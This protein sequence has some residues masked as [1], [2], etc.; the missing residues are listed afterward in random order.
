MYDDPVQR[1]TLEGILR[2]T[3]SS[4]EIAKDGTLQIEFYD[5]SDEAEQMMDGDVAYRLIVSADNK[6]RLL[7]LLA[8]DV[9]PHAGS[10]V[11][12][13]ERMKER[14]RCYHDVRQWLDAQGIKYTKTSVPFS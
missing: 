6:L 4:I 2:H 11:Q 3:S 5:F 13:L 9:A 14:F 1:I 7:E 10:D 12:L 8:P